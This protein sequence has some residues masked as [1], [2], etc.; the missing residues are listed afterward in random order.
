[1]AIDIISSLP[2]SLSSPSRRG[3]LRSAG[4]GALALVTG[5][6]IPRL[7]E[8]QA[9]GL[10]AAFAAKAAYVNA[11]YSDP[12][13]GFSGIG[14]RSPTI[15]GQLATALG[16]VQ[17]MLNKAGVTDTQVAQAAAMYP[18]NHGAN[19]N[20]CQYVV[21]QAGW[22]PPLPNDFFTLV[23]SSSMAADMGISFLPPPASMGALNG[24]ISQV[25]GILQQWQYGNFAAAQPRRS[26]KARLELASYLRQVDF[27]TNTNTVAV[28]GA[29]VAATG[30]GLFL[31][32]GGVA[33]F[34][35]TAPAVPALIAGAGAALLV[36]GV[37]AMVYAAYRVYT[38]E[39]GEPS[40]WTVPS[41]MPSNWWVPRW[42]NGGGGNAPSTQPT[43]WSRIV[44][45]DCPIGQ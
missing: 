3:F 18:A 41:D 36:L 6:A 7:V 2:P 25:A 43:T 22:I 10:T 24:G 16:S 34:A 45:Y 4:G 35:L 33:M 38:Q 13:T 23:D 37:G 26:R 17:A 30:L 19:P 40:A 28:I 9:P 15:F 11:G 31:G 21:S 8:A 44:C 29:G 42:A 12:T 14:Y 20:F 32:A 5:A 39:Q 1:M 27:S